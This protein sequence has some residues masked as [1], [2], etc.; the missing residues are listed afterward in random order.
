MGN[1][2]ARKSIQSLRQRIIEHY[3][4][5]EREQTKP[6]P[7]EGLI[8]HWQSEI[9]AF[10]TRLRRLENRLAQRQRRGRS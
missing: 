6:E 9:E 8:G 2:A 10:T 7:D 1:R 4:K 3:A 5:I